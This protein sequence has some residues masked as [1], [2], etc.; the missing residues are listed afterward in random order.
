MMSNPSS[1]IKKD[2]SSRILATS[3]PLRP[4][5]S[6]FALTHPLFP[7]GRSGKAACFWDTSW[8]DLIHLIWDGSGLHKQQKEGKRLIC[9]NSLTAVLCPSGVNLNHHT[10]NAQ[11]NH[12][13]KLKRCETKLRQKTPI[14]IFMNI[15]LCLVLN[16]NNQCTNGSRYSRMDHVKF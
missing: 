9:L 3:N 15:I 16:L 2:W 8:S 11:T 4:I 6:C 14:F 13:F 7:N 10:Q 12:F 5:T 1:L